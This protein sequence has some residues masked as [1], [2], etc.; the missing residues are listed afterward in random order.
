[1]VVT[2][3]LPA[4]QHF[5]RRPPGQLGL[6]AMSRAALADPALRALYLLGACSVGALVA[7]F[8]ALGFRLT[9]GPHDLGLGAV[10]LLY[11]VYVL[12]TLS[13]TVSGRL[14]DRFGRRAILPAGCALAITGVLLTLLP[15]CPP[16]WSAS[17]G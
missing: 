17:P 15:G 1:M 8:N 3:A 11:L 16:S 2:L 13:S 7:V 9:S 5:Q 10:S 4:S 12:G 14:A 6:A